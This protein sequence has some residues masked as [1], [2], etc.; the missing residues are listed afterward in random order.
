MDPAAVPATPGRHPGRHRPQQ[1]TW[2]ARS[3]DASPDRWKR[4]DRDPAV[5]LGGFTGRGTSGTLLHNADQL[6]ASWPVTV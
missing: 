2:L 1:R 3:L 4:A 5:R 6:T